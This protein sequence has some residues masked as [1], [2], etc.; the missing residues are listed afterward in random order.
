MR[1]VV[2]TE[3]VPLCD[4]VDQHNFRAGVEESKEKL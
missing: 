1:S 3:L 2:C 4:S